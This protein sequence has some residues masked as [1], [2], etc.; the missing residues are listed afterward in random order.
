MS[1]NE[2]DQKVKHVEKKLVLV[3]KIQFIKS[4][5]LTIPTLSPFTPRH[6]LITSFKTG[7]PRERK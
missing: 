3:K 5:K 4:R 1:Q 7:H 6:Y 2:I